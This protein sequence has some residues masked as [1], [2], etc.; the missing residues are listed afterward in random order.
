MFNLVVDN[1]TIG[2]MWHN[3]TNGYICQE[4]FEI[5]FHIQLR[6]PLSRSSAP[7]AI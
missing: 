6:T 5:Y 1:V 7:G 2:N 3:V 4:G